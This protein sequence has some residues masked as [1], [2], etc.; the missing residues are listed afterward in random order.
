[1]S[2]SFRG[3]SVQ[4]LRRQGSGSG[5]F[6][7][8]YIGCSACHRGADTGP[9]AILNDTFGNDPADTAHAAPF[10]NL[11]NADI[12]GQCRARYS[13][14][15]SECASWS[16]P[17]GGQAPVAGTVTPQ[18]TLGDF[19]PL[20]TPPTWAPAPITDFLNVA[21]AADP[22]GNVFWLGGQSAK[23]HGQG[24]V[25]YEEW[26]ATDHADALAD[27]KAAVGPNPRAACLKCHSTDYAMA[28][29]AGRTEEPAA[30]GA[31]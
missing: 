27:L 22:V 1:M 7:E 6:S 31:A 10:A 18:Y 17:S 16:W 9:N 8:N 25:Q 19:N 14:T 4:R 26:M 5:G 24:A 12:C 20:G 2:E 13:E 30:E 15:A 28:V 29:E 23:A 3:S 11:A 21:T